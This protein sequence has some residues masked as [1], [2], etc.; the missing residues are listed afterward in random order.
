MEKF[1]F[2]H[3]ITNPQNLLLCE[4]RYSLL[5]IFIFAISRVTGSLIGLAIGDALGAPLEGYPP[6][7]RLLTGMRGGGVHRLRRGGVTDDT[8]QAMAV[9]ESLVI[10]GGFDPPDIVRRFLGGYIA[11]PE[12]YGPT[13]GAVF[14]LIR[15]GVPAYEAARCVHERTGGTR[16]NGS[17]MRGAPIGIFYPPCVVAGVSVACSHLTHFDHTAAECSAF[18]NRMIS[19]LCRGVDPD[20]AYRHALSG[21]LDR[22]VRYRMVSPHS[23]PLVSSLDA[24]DTLHCAVSIFLGARSFSSAVKTAVNLGGDSDTAGAVTGALSGAYWGI[25]SIPGD[26]LA[27]LTIREELLVLSRNLYRSAIA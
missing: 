21:C 20:A 11:H 2:L 17:V 7:S 27:A 13:S 22:E 16:T 5:V 26:W 9:A 12:F 6:P 25:L 19:E 14:D 10:R 3:C 24:L 4:T 1:F 23:R 18:L 15:Q 8:L